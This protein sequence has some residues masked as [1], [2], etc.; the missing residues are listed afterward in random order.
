MKPQIDYA[1][2][3]RG[4]ARMEDMGKARELLRVVAAAAAEYQPAADTA[5]STITDHI[6]ATADKMRC[7]SVPALLP[8]AWRF[9]RHG[10]ALS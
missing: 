9:R 5:A 10:P 8:P 2:I 4:A 1:R 6:A 7:G 3:F